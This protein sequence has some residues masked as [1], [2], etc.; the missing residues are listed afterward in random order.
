LASDINDLR[1]F[2]FKHY[3][4]NKQGY[5]K[6]LFIVAISMGYG[7]MLGG[8]LNNCPA[9]S[10]EYKNADPVVLLSPSHPVEHNSQSQISRR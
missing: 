2:P 4:R 9:L 1:Y 5:M 6:K 7:L 8:V 3:V 10:S